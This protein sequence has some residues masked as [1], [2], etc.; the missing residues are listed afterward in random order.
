MRNRCLLLALALGLTLVLSSPRQTVDAAGGD[1]KGERAQQLI[2][3]LGSTKFAVRERAKKEL[4]SM[5]PAALEALRKAARSEDMET[6]RRAGEL[7]KK[8]ED[9]LSFDN[10]LQ[11]KKVNLRLKDVSVMEAIEELSKQSGYPIQVDGD[12]TPLAKRKITLETGETTFWQAFDQV[13]QKGGLSEV[14]PQ[15]SPYGTT[16]PPLRQPPIQIQPIQIQPIQPLPMNPPIQLKPGIL[17]PNARDKEMLERL[18]KLLDQ[19][20]KELDG[21][22]KGGIKLQPLPLPNLLPPGPNGKGGAPAQ[23]LEQ[24]M[25]KLLEKMLDQLQKDAPQLPKFKLPANGVNANFNFQVNQANGQA[26]QPGQGGQGGQGGAAVVQAK[27]KAKLQKNVAV[28]AAQVQPAQAQPAIGRITQPY[29]PNTPNGPITVRDGA[30]KTYP[31]CYAGAVRVRV[32]PLEHHPGVAKRDGEV[33]VLLEVCGEPRMQGFGAVGNAMIDK[34]LDEHGQS[35]FVTMDPVADNNQV[36][37]PNGR[38][39]IRSNVYPNANQP[40]P[41]V[42][43][44]LKAGEKLSKAL[45]QLSGNLTAQ[46][47]S[48]PEALITFNDL[49]N[50]GGKEAKGADGGKVDIIAVNKLNNGDVRVQMRLEYANNVYRATPQ[51]GVGF[52]T[53][54]GVAN[55]LDAKGKAYQFAG[56][57]PT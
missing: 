49:L 31:T 56:Q 44:R 2:K 15:Y 10:M 28:Q 34:A 18:Q 22:G 9:K 1:D 50:A 37:N 27:A 41:F 11:P 35:L 40:Q 20:Q 45:K 54:Q 14:T 38:V 51:T 13:C 39:L 30:P 47:L 42:V 48:E 19:L 32:V 36:V 43:V 24:E 21:N 46:F 33:A 17:M 53:I 52:N 26:G 7:V 4:E 5:G 12:R 16:R 25:Q 23:K 6:S 55:V 8:M 57:T 3:Q 29:R